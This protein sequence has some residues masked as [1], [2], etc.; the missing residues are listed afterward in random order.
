MHKILPV[1]GGVFGLL[2]A[3]FVGAQERPVEP[4]ETA[5]P[6]VVAPQT[7]KI[8]GAEVGRGQTVRLEWNPSYGIGGLEASAPVLVA[9]GLNPG[10]VLCVTAAIHGDEL[11]GIEIVRR[12]M[13]SLDPKDLNGTV[14]GVPIVNLPGFQRGSRYLPDRRDLNRHFPG[15]KQGSLASRIGADFFKN[16]VL[17]CNYVVDVH[18]GS[19]AR[20]NLPQLRADMRI[21]EVL[22]MTKR[23]G[24]IAVL[25]TPAA[26]GTLR[27]AASDAGIPTVTLEAGEPERLQP[28][29]VAVGLKGIE[30]FMNGMK[31][32]PKQMIWRNPQPVYYQSRWVRADRGGIL[33][34]SVK[35]G[36]R[37]Q[38]GDMLGT[39][40]D[41]ISNARTEVIAP[42]DGRV[43]GKALNQFVM[44]GFAAFRLGVQTSEDKVVEDADVPVP[45]TSVGVILDPDPDPDDDKEAN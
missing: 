2:M 1:V 6:E 9:H 38:V 35:L 16:I 13:Q 37:V 34:T 36:D 12:V 8:L 40:T 7:F 45:D 28:N 41:P 27:R 21:P 44:P 5:A 39:V 24:A 17:H 33:F 26:R 3:G 25:H 14:I 15:D 32:T 4:V 22:E 19:F 29:E 18:T 42:M 31:M 43:L 11:N 20:A 30:S 23:F 10:P